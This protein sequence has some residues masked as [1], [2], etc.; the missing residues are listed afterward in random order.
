MEV[1]LRFVVFCLSHPCESVCVCMG[2]LI[3]VY[4]LEQVY[5]ECIEDVEK[6]YE[7]TKR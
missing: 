2:V 1:N 5:D 7:V 6:T 4:A 3:W